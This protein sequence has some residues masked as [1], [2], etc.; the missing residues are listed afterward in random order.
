MRRGV[1]QPCLIHWIPTAHSPTVITISSE[2]LT[3]PYWSQQGR[4]PASPVPSEET[5]SVDL[6]PLCGEEMIW[7]SHFQMICLEMVKAHWGD[8]QVL[9][10]CCENVHC[11]NVTTKLPHPAQLT[12]VAF[13]FLYESLASLSLWHCPVFPL[14]VCLSVSRSR[15]CSLFLNDDTERQL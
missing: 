6:V 5:V 11:I 2:C 7:F 12:A 9:P 4:Q 10:R 8:F 3:V 15:L 1:S 13:L 14:S